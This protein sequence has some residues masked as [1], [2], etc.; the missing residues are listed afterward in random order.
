MSVTPEDLLIVQKAKA[1]AWEMVHSWLCQLT[2]YPNAIVQA[3]GLDPNFRSSFRILMDE[4]KRAR[5]HIDD[6]IDAIPE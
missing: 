3:S 5:K 4:Y 1:D 2:Y 6:T